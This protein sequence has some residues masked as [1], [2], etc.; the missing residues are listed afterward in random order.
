MHGLHRV[1]LGIFI[2]YVDYSAVSTSSCWLQRCLYE[3]VL[4]TAL[5]ARARVDCSA[6][7]T[8]SCWLQRCLYELVVSV[9]LSV[10]A[11]VNC[12]VA[13]TS[14][15]WLQR[16]HCRSFCCCTVLSFWQRFSYY[17]IIITSTGSQSEF[18][19]TVS[20]IHTAHANYV[21]CLCVK[22]PAKQ[23]T[24]TQQQTK[25]YVFYKTWVRTDWNYMIV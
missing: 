3:L 2:K 7:C 10:R 15:C 16:S 12:N 5:S 4:T 11:R 14:S 1:W 23:Q 6:I 22:R 18:T 20:N 21:M 17:V 9:A 13:C 24:Y 25:C 19:C 8:S